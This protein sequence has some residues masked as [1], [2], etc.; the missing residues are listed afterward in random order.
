MRRRSKRLLVVT[1]SRGVKRRYNGYTDGA[2]TSDLWQHI[3]EYLDL[4][5]CCELHRVSTHVAAKLSWPLYHLAM[6]T[7]EATR[8]VQYYHPRSNWGIAALRGVPLLHRY[9]LMMHF[10]HP[11]EEEW[12]IER[13]MPSLRWRI[14][15]DTWSSFDPL[16]DY[17]PYAS[18]FE[19]WLVRARFADGAWRVKGLVV[20]Q[21][22]SGM[23]WEFFRREVQLD[24]TP[25][26]ELHV[27]WNR[28][29]RTLMEQCCH[30]LISL[31]F[32]WQSRGSI[33]QGL[34][35]IV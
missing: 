20:G 21:L 8:I 33:T 9:R 18:H 6:V 25:V 4:H 10:N 12:L 16:S 15:L 30:Q 5:G 26:H 27:Q 22:F 31:Y 17:Y 2:I 7:S 28:T 24:D 35:R 1:T 13:A 14:T 19:L 34:S 29:P 3:S 11:L 23:R 32:L